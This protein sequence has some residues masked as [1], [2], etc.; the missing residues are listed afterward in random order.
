MDEHDDIAYIDGEPFP[1]E[2][3][4]MTLVDAYYIPNDALEAYIKDRDEMAAKAMRIFQKH[5]HSVRRDY[6]GSQD[7]EALIGCDEDGEI[8]LFIHL[9]P[10]GI[11]AMKTADEN[12]E[13]E[14]WLL[15][16]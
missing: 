1:V 15:E 9:D 16:F 12:G 5:C 2:A 11:D 3:D 10:D 7:G 14:R 13:L 4:G 8:M 6:A